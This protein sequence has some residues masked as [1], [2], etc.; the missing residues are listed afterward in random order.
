MPGKNDV[1][2]QKREKAKDSHEENDKKAKAINNDRRYKKSK[3]GRNR[4]RKQ[5]D[6]VK[7]LAS[8][9]SVTVEEFQTST[10]SVNLNFKSED[11]R[12][13]EFSHKQPPKQ[14]IIKSSDVPLPLK[15]NKVT[16]SYVSKKQSAFYKGQKK[17]PRNKKQPDYKTPEGIKGPSSRVLKSKNRS[18]I[19][20][21]DRLKINSE[22]VFFIDNG[23]KGQAEEVLSL[24]GAF[25]DLN[26]RTPES[27][28]RTPLR[29][30][31]VSSEAGKR[32]AKTT[33]AALIDKL[34]DAMQEV[35]QKNKR[36]P[37]EKKIKGNLACA[38]L[39]IIPFDS[40]EEQLFIKIDDDES[41]K[42]L[43]PKVLFGNVVSET[44]QNF[45]SLQKSYIDHDMLKDP[46]VTRVMTGKGS[47]KSKDDLDAGDLVRRN[48]HHS[49][50]FIMAALKKP[51]LA[52]KERGVQFD[53]STIIL[54]IATKFAPCNH[55]VNRMNGFLNE[56]RN[57]IFPG[58]N[59]L[60]ARVSWFQEYSKGNSP[61]EVSVKYHNKLHPQETRI[62]EIDDKDRNYMLFCNVTPQMAKGIKTHKTPSGNSAS[63]TPTVV[64]S[65]NESLKKDLKDAQGKIGLELGT[66]QKV[67]VSPPRRNALKSSPESLQNLQNIY[68][69]IIG[70]G[71]GS[72]IL[73]GSS[74]LDTDLDSLAPPSIKRSHH[75]NLGNMFKSVSSSSSYF[76]LEA[77]KE[78]EKPHT[79]YICESQFSAHRQSFTSLIP[80]CSIG[81]QDISCSMSYHYKQSSAS[82]V[83]K[84]LSFKDALVQR[85][86]ET[87]SQRE[88]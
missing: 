16:S 67:F 22:H 57:E 45:A 47:K 13:R 6:Y 10:I 85:R 65:V 77:G 36:L 21:P 14:K 7:S 60:V 79:E 61:S 30:R 9:T 1:K 66:G 28:P 82:Q 5:H 71:I 38:Q 78:N 39:S 24:P 11:V 81:G 55:C 19:P 50:Q 51:L 25:T 59:Y 75:K 48:T 42:V 15:D 23:T 74:L 63:Q 80:Q 46:A 56:I 18:S 31:E 35:S 41:K 27:M 84:R 29:A 40:S 53:N 26:I 44:Y 69:Q 12:S 88:K 4:S 58:N 32:C 68:D 54:D 20:D 86:K 76:Q 34:A 43:T 87:E 3:S 17:Y 62:P 70:D 73:P 49:E 83:T 72:P 8:S 52:L 37:Y 33:Q 64:S 2:T